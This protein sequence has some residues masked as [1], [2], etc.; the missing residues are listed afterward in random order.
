MIQA[1]IPPDRFFSRLK[2][3]AC[4]TPIALALRIP[5]LQCTTYDAA[6]S[7]SE[8]R[9]ASS[10]KRDHRRPG[11]PADRDFFRVAHVQNDRLG[12]LIEQS[13]ELKRSDLV[14][15]VGRDRLAP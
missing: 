5:L 3:A 11:N 14:V 6:W 13:L 10:G 9:P 8:R 1:R 15:A 4:M 7:S 2:P 12:A